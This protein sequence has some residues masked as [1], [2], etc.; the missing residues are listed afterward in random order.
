MDAYEILRA[1]STSP[2]GSDVWTLINTQAG[3]S[4]GIVIVGGPL[5]VDIS[6]ELTANAGDALSADLLMDSLSANITLNTSADTQNEL[7]AEI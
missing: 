4:G 3:G 2:T 1:N 5:T 7:E 6:M